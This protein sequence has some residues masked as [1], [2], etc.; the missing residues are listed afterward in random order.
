MAPAND[1]PYTDDTIRREFAQEDVRNVHGVMIRQR[2]RLTQIAD[3]FLVGNADLARETA[4]QIAL[5]MANIAH[6]FPASEAKAS[7][8]WKLMS[9]VTLQAESIQKE[10]AG[11]N[12]RMAYNHYVRLQASCIQCHQVARS[13]GK[14]EEPQL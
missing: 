2:E 7:Q 8:A 3:A 10:L 9:E 11:K 5:D 12:Y 4:D 14:F 6:A 1:V 13:W